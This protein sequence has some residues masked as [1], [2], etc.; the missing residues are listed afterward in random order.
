MNMHPLI[1]K[2][3]DNRGLDIEK[4]TNY[5]LSNLHNPNKIPSINN[6]KR[7]LEEV[8]LWNGKVGVVS[9]FDVDGTT[10]AA[11]MSKVLEEMDIDYEVRV[12]TRQQEGYGYKKYSVDCLDDCQLIITLDCGINAD[13]TIDYAFKKGIK[14]FVI[15]HHQKDS[16]K[17]FNYIDLEAKEG[18]Y[19]HSELSAGALT[20]K[21]AK[22][23]IGDKAHNLIQ[24]AALSTVAD[25]MDMSNLE[26]RTIVH[27][28][29][30]KMNSNPLTGIKSLMEVAGVDTIDAG[31]I[32]YQI[33][34]MI[35]AMG[36]LGNNEVSYQLLTEN[37]LDS[38]YPLAEKLNKINKKRKKITKNALKRVENNAD[39]SKNC[40]IEKMDVEKGITGLVAGKLSNK[41]DVPVIIFNEEGKGSGRSVGDYDFRK[42]IQSNCINYEYVK[43]HSA[44]FGASLG[45]YG[46]EYFKEDVYNMTEGVE[47]D[48]ADYDVELNPAAI[49]DYLMES[50]DDLKPFGIGFEKPKFCFNNEGITNIQ[51]MGKDNEHIRFN[52]HK[53]N[54]VAFYMS[55]MKDKLEGKCDIIYTPGWNEWMGKKEKQLIVSKII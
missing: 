5:D 53:V 3:F 18:R 46:I 11:I 16:R 20:W 32:G 36:R 43:G 45:D 28:G 54:T 17:Q 38:A 47:Y 14:T 37:D 15:D 21:I 19:P 26:N 44:A 24:L 35:N 2:V 10:S 49:D 31:K 34:P 51:T 4:L 13:D 42:E 27:Y 41:Y 52:W 1:Q 40:I 30:K 39:L 25:M 6:L 50:L 33:A 55:D 29:I 12:T 23:L 7:E 8:K 9:D 48:V 22:Y